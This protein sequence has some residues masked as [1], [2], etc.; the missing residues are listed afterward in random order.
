VPVDALIQV[1]FLLLLLHSLLM[2]LLLLLLLP[3]CA[4]AGFVGVLK[5]H[6]LSKI[7]SCFPDGVRLIERDAQVRRLQ[8]CEP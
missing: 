6:H 8:S 4:T 2:L 5:R 3:D 7:H 1:T